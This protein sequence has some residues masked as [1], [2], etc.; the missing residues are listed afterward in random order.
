MGS[1]AGIEWRDE[2][3]K[4]RNKNKK[5][6]TKVNNTKQSK[7]YKGDFVSCGISYLLF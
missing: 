4:N 5:C 6:A 2:E 7:T 3:K 1:S